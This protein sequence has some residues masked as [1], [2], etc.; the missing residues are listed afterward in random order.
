M[1]DLFDQSTE[2]MKKA[3]DAWEKTMEDSPW[4]RKPDTSVLGAWGPWFATMRSTYDVNVNA[5]RT[6]VDHG[7]ET[8]FKALKESPVHNDAVE[9]QLREMWDGM[10]KAADVQK[11]IVVGTL[12][13]MESLL[14]EKE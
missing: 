10:K 11:E 9:K 8:F 7:E 2:M 1:K 13:R 14:K 3:W 12:E 6:M 5:W 4:L